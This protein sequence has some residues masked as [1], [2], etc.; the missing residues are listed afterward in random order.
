MDAVRSGFS[1]HVDRGAFGAAVHSGKSLRGDLKFL[2]RL[3]G[4]LHDGAANRIVLIVNA[5]HRHIHITA[6]LPIH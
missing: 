4:K 1:D 2:H 3:C 5:I 6:A